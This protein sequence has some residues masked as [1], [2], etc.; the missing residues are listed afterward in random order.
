MEIP[1]FDAKLAGRLAR[2]GEITGVDRGESV[3][4]IGDFMNDE[5]NDLAFALNDPACRKHRCR[6]DHA[7][8]GLEQLTLSVV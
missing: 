6:Q 7:P 5:V 8:V 3:G 4:K 2:H 1:A